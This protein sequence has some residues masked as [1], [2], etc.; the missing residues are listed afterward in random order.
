MIR[1]VKRKCIGFQLVLRPNS[2]LI[3]VLSRDQYLMLLLIVAYQLQSGY[4]YG[5]IY[6]STCSHVLLSAVCVMYTA[7]SIK[8]LLLKF[9]N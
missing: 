1:F 4:S 3:A 9:N 7:L 5:L 2:H 6:N 8:L